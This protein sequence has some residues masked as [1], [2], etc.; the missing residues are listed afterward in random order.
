MQEFTFS[1]D[2]DEL[3]VWEAFARQ[4]GWPL[5]Y[6][7]ETVVPKQ[8]THHMLFTLANPEEAGLA[9]EAMNNVLSE[10]VRKN[11]H[12]FLDSLYEPDSE[13]GQAFCLA[14]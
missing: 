10:G 7:V 6:L 11:L 3:R 5:K 2:D 13:T 14:E 4:R 8:I 12:A 9:M 1:I